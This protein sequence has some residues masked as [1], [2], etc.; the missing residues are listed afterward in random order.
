MVYPKAYK[1]RARRT[2]ERRAAAEL[3]QQKANENKV[4]DEMDVDDGCSKNH[5]A[6]QDDIS[7]TL[8][9]DNLA[10]DPFNMTDITEALEA[11]VRH[12]TRDNLDTLIRTAGRDVDTLL[13]LATN[14]Q[15]PQ[16]AS[17]AQVESNHAH[18]IQWE[19]VRSLYHRVAALEGLRTAQPAATTVA[20]V[21]QG[22][23]ACY[24]TMFATLNARID[25]LQ[26]TLSDLQATI[27]RAARPHRSGQRGDDDGEDDDIMKRVFERIKQ[28]SQLRED[29]E[30]NR[31]EQAD[32]DS[33]AR[34]DEISDN[35]DELEE[36]L[37]VIEQDKDEMNRKLGRICLF[38]IGHLTGDLTKDELVERLRELI[39]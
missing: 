6:A 3:A 30:A 4:D 23:N 24:S 39:Y 21:E 14:G 2:A 12:T 26:T 38:L 32:M 25:A 36:K 1:K 27:N 16:Q 18:K 33:E 17:N 34:V 5:P 29:A 20:N 22:N 10:V 31:F 9:D 15:H 19:H 11:A 28:V 37:N 13:N 7:S 35:Q 8:N